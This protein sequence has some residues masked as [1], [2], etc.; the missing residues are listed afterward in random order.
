MKSG[1]GA[2]MYL[3]NGVGKN[4]EETGKYLGERSGTKLKRTRGETVRNLGI[5]FLMTFT[6]ELLQNCTRK[7]VGT[8]YIS[9]GI[10]YDV[11]F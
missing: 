9:N 8:E 11:G 1:I 6:S 10:R 5:R 3:S 4:C 2:G 7:E